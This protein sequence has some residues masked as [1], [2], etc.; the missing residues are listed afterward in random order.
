MARRLRRW[1]S[2]LGVFASVLVLQ[3]PIFDRW[4]SLMDEGHILQFA[5][6]LRRGGEL[7][8]DATLVAFPG[9]F[10]LLAWLFELFEPSI[11]LARFVV[12]SEFSLLAAIVY[13]MLRGRIA[14]PFVWLGLVL[15]LLYRIWAFPHWQMYSY[16]TTSLT[17]IA[18]ALALVVA[19]ITR[20]DPRRDRWRIPCAGLI[21]GLAVACKQDYGGAAV[22]AL[23]AVLV[24]AARTRPERP[25]L[26]PRLLAF[27]GAGLLVGAVIAVHYAS[28]GLLTEMLRQTI[29]NHLV[30]IATFEYSSLPPVLP[31]FSQVPE[32]RSTYGFAVYT[33]AILFSM[34]WP[35]VSGSALYRD[36]ILWDLAIRALF[37]GPYL[38]A[39]ASLLRVVWRR[40]ALRDPARRSAALL[41]LALACL[42]ALL[43][44]TLNKPKDWV[45]MAVVYWPLLC[46]LVVHLDALQRAR[47]R[48]ARILLSALALPAALAVAYTADL[49]WML[50]ARDDTPLATP[51]A[52]VRVT[53]SE[54]HVI[55]G[56]VDY[57]RTNTPE[58]SRVAVLPYFPLLNFL[59]E[60]DAP[61]RS[62]YVLWPVEDVP[63]RQEQI[64][65]A[66]EATQAP[67]VLYHFTQW[68]QFPSMQEYAPD[69]FAYLVD[70]YAIDRVFTDDGWGYMMAGLVRES[71]PPR[72]TP[73]FPDDLA[74]A[75][76]R[77]EGPGAAAS[78][79]PSGERDRWLRREIWPFRPVLALRP[80]A[81][82]R[83]TVA[84]T[85]LRIPPHASL[86]TAIGV[87]P[88]RWFK[89][90]PSWVRFG[91][92][93]AVGGES[94]E[95]FS[96]TLDPHRHG[97]DRG[98]FDVSLPLDAWAGRDVQLELV[99]EV[100]RDNSEV[101][102][103]GGF[104]WPRIVLG[105]DRPLGGGQAPVAGSTPV[106][107]AGGR[108]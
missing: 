26:L 72:G 5:D 88:R 78:R 21:A 97:G 41:E 39:A 6:L 58:G 31:L 108:P 67:H 57:L 20:P 47:P 56:A 60:R 59:A 86:E 55:D 89:F 69:L 77:V 73:L 35:R 93:V 2:P 48:A 80:H 102:E 15:L 38:Y 42:A 25:R 4:V 17:L 106:P 71:E 62:T 18:A 33:P 95:I 79:I 87:N 107:P 68:I 104:S 27:D 22:L 70:H 24:V 66:L 36:T 9:C 45:H 43:V 91:V 52:G 84:S 101:F 23:N 103:M 100:E 82:G 76:V 83:R 14:R 94:Q 51:R 74:T 40:R 32:L 19:V 16:S 8:R 28:A 11:R 29:W 3:L 65:A 30:G 46:L 44:F 13:A 34:D 92:R 99:T 98:W 50:R 12:A 37:Y 53:A 64:A 1:L 7:Y 85:S 81:G 75:S 96:R 54:A 105:K 61:H 10:Y 63:H 90:P 49:A